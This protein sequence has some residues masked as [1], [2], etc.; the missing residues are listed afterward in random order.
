MHQLA[1]HY[2]CCLARLA[3]LPVRS[4]TP[5]FIVLSADRDLRKLRNNALRAG[6]DFAGTKPERNASSLHLSL[7]GNNHRHGGEAG[8]WLNEARNA[9]SSRSSPSASLTSLTFYPLPLVIVDR[10]AKYFHL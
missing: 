6:L 8:G 2:A 1:S 10:P 7:R 3:R 9:G 5:G 4:L